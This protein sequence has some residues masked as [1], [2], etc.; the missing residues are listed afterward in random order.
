VTAI[1]A[2]V[3]DLGGVLIDWNPRHL[4]RKMF[5]T[6]AE[7]EEFLSTVA[8]MA[9]NDRLDRGEPFDQ[10]VAELTAEFPDHAEAIAAY[11]ERWTEM[12]AGAMGDT[13]EVLAEVQAAGLPT[14]ALSNWSEQ[15]FRLVRDQFDFL[16][17]FDGILL[18]S[19]VGVT[20][21]DPAI[22]AELCRRFGLEPGRT[23]FVDDNPPNVDGARAAGLQALR[24]ESAATLRGDLRG[25]GVLP[26]D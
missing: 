25:L 5:A 3:F 7:M 24:F 17:S 14:Y 10:A 20:K 15:T 16:E 12:I 2:V 23:L 26:R 18:S 4:Y 8:T 13:V 21:P 19:Q 1:K 6:E 11:I 9:W 22:Y